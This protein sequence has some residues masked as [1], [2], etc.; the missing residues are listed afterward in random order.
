MLKKS[1]VLAG[2]LLL[3]ACGEST[4]NQTPAQIAAAACQ[5]EAIVRIGEKTHQID[6]ATLAA[7]A[8]QNDGDWEMSAPVVVSP[9]LRDEVKQTLDCRVRL[10]EGKPP[11][12][13]LINFVF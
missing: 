2:V 13:I 4:S 11:E 5:A 7:S 3:A 1:M 10:T 6:L 9:G 8:K 12:I